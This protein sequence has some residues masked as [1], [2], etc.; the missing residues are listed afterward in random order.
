MGLFHL[1]FTKQLCYWNRNNKGY[2]YFE[3]IPCTGG[4][5]LGTQGTVISIILDKDSIVAT[6]LIMKRGCIVIPIICNE[7][8]LEML[9]IL[10][11]R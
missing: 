1:I 8:N 7:S 4:F 9:K 6:W 11:K 2:I 3:K 5:P 10:E